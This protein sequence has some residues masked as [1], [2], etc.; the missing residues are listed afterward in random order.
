MVDMPRVSLDALRE[1]LRPPPG[2]RR[3]L[4]N[5]VESDARR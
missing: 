4:I 2:E 5:V 3:I 1:L